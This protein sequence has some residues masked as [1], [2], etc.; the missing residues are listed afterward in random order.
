LSELD[1]RRWV[2]DE[3]GEIRQR[4]EGQVLA[5]VPAER[6]FEQ[7]GGGNSIGYGLWHLAVHADFALHGVLQGEGPMLAA[8]GLPTGCGLAEA[9][10]PLVATLDPDLV[11][12]R[13]GEVL[14]DAA[15]WL[16]IADVAGLDRPVDASAVLAD[17]GVPDD[18]YGWLYRM[19]DG[20][21]AAYFLRWELIGH[22]GNHVG[23]MI[24]T[25]N[26]MGLSPF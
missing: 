6:R 12:H 4:L 22:V 24:A 3:L 17:A 16:T 23:E 7:P 5:I 20:K 13:L 26:R 25:R 15:R 19:W 1:V 14:D 11:V 18:S 2:A 21:T 10:D 9:E 8:G